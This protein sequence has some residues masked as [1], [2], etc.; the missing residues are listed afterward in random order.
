MVHIYPMADQIRLFLQQTL[1]LF[2]LIG[3]F[4]RHGPLLL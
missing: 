3:T 1:M 2:N 4:P